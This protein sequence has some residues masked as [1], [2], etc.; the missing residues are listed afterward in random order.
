M[1]DLLASNDGPSEGQHHDL[2]DFMEETATE[3]A[4]EYTR[5]TRR[6]KEDPGTAGDEAE[7]N[8]QEILKGYLPPSLPVVTKGRILGVDGR[9][10]P[11]VD[12]L[13]LSPNYPKRLLGRK[14]YLASG[15]LAAFECKL[16][17]RQRDLSKIGENARLIR[18]LAPENEP[19]VYGNL[20]SSII[21]GVLAHSSE[22]SSH[23]DPEG[24]DYEF[25]LDPL[26]D[27]PTPLD[28]ALKR[29]M[30]RAAHPR[31]LLDVLCIADLACYERDTRVIPGKEYFSPGDWARLKANHQISDEGEVSTSYFRPARFHSL[32]NAT[33]SA[34]FSFIVKILYGISWKIPSCQAMAE[35]WRL[36]QNEEVRELR[37]G[38][39]RSWPLSVLSEHV[40]AKIEAGSLE[41]GHCWC[42]WGSKFE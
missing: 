34:L 26:R 7:S 6:S 36:S 13:V 31:D 40:L 38:P 25:R 19:S 35:Y 29:L 32:G 24:P 15:V 39:S 33:E 17:L 8:W 21:Y 4:R 12:V 11:Q 16:T 23:A 18:D 14:Q 41:Q 42:G 22:W 30:D 20:H 3:L 1:T 28:G 37:C 10:S 5:I 2:H 27:W 9:S